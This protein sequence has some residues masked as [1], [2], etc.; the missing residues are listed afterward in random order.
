MNG[1]V[2]NQENKVL[3]R[4]KAIKEIIEKYPIEDQSALVE[5]LQEKYGIESTQSIISRDLHQLGIGKRKVKEK[6]LYDLPK[7]NL[8]KEIL[9]LAI[10]DIVHNES[11]IIIKTIPG[12]ADFVGDFIDSQ[13]DIEVIGSLSGENTVFVAP[14]ST[15][16]IKTIYT[17][18]CKTVYFKTIED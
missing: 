6:M 15:K 13:K 17:K 14:K 8:E 16:K 4:H 11:L 3:L 18:V 5:V 1:K 9:R 10:T 2:M 7:I 12:I